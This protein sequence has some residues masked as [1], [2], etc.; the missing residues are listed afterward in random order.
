MPWAF[1]IQNRVAE[2]TSRNGRVEETT[3]S[4]AATPAASRPNAW[5]SSLRKHT[6]G[7][8]VRP[9]RTGQQSAF[10][11]RVQA[12]QEDRLLGDGMLLGGV[13]HRQ[14]LLSVGEHP[15]ARPGY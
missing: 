12:V 15:D 13:R 11:D 1:L 9:K 14:G 4:N 7:S 3:S 10:E 6:L 5:R 8:R 2:P